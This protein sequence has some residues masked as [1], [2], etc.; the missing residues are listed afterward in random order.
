MLRA[1][2]EGLHA[3]V[4]EVVIAALDGDNTKNAYTVK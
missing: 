2:A 1:V 3:V 4:Q